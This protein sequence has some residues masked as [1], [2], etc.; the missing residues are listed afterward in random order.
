MTRRQTE[1]FPRPLLAAVAGF[2]YGGGHELAMLCDIVIAGAR[3]RFAQPE[4]EIGIL[5]GDGATQ[6]IPRSAGKSLAM[7]L[8]LSG[9]P[10]DAEAALR[11]SLIHISEPTRPY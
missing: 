1:R 5:P 4:I 3:A 9:A 7:K 2:A 8:V 11:L 10:I 6:R